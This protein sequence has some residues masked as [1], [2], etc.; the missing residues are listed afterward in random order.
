MQ[1]KPRFQELRET[2]YEERGDIMR[3]LTKK[4]LARRLNISYEIV[5]NLESGKKQDYSIEILKAYSIFFG[6]TVDYLLGLSNAKTKNADI[7]MISDFTGLDVESILMLHDISTFDDFIYKA[8]YKTIECLLESNNGLGL[9]RDIALYLFMPPID[10]II[11][12]DKGESIIY[13][14]TKDDVIPFTIKD[15]TYNISYPANDFSNIVLLENIKNEL[16][17]IKSE[18][19]GKTNG[20]ETDTA[21]KRSRKR[22]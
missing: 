18:K 3:D 8:L 9:L 11:A 10:G 22:K 13:Y 21:R 1:S 14:F 6:V 19:E 16:K 5:K 4:E 20:K 7:K 15:T 2:Y 12:N 17:T